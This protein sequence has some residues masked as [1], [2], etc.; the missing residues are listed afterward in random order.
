M[1][2][3]DIGPF[4]LVDP[5]PGQEELI[6]ATIEA[7]AFPWTLLADRIHEDSDKAIIVEW[8]DNMVPNTAS[9][10]YYGGTNRIVMSSLARNLDAGAGFVFAHEVGHMIDDWF[11]SEEYQQ[12]IIGVMHDGDFVQ[13]GHFNHDHPDAGHLKETWWNGSDA[14]VSRIYEAFADQFVAA[15]APSVWDGSFF[16]GAPKRYPRFVHWTDKH[17]EIKEIVLESATPEPPTPAPV[18]EKEEEPMFRDVGLNHPKRRAIERAVRLGLMEPVNE[19]R[20][21]FRP[22]LKVNRAQ[23]AEMLLAVYDRRNKR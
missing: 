6:R 20:R 17:A 10:L 16:P 13:L 12:R 18:P 21:L 7:I 11:L 3:I 9:G 5:P 8:T 4:R 23:V 22:G 2:T 1:P 14:Y 19:K 15:F